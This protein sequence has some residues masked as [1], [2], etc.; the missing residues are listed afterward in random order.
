MLSKKTETIKK[1]EQNNSDTYY[2]QKVNNSFFDNNIVSGKEREMDVPFTSD[3]VNR[4]VS[5]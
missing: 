4:G 5:R 3:T 2:Y 1:G